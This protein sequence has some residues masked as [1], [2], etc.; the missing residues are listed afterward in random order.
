MHI[1]PSTFDQ[2]TVTEATQI[3]KDLKSKI[4]LTP[5]SKKIKTIAGAD[6]SFQRFGKTFYGG[7]VIFS[8]PALKPIARSLAVMETHFPY[9]PGYLSF[10]EIPCLLKAWNMIPEKPDVLIVDGQGIA[11]PRR[12]GL[13]AHFGILIDSCTIGCAKTKLYGTYNEPA[14]EKGKYSRLKAGDEIIGCVLRTKDKVKPLFV[15]PGNNVSINQSRSIVLKSV[16]AHRMPEPTR[17]A[18]YYVNEFRKGNMEEGYEE[19]GGVN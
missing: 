15:S 2:L 8:Y 16:L 3:Q 7:I 5:F 4:N 10:R 18:H 13:A 14:P 6:I 19:I 11:H 12:T 1:D 17:R 9:V